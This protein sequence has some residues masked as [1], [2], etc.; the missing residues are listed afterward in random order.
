MSGMKRPGLNRNGRIFFGMQR[1]PTVLFFTACMVA[2]FFFAHAENVLPTPTERAS[3]SDSLS[4]VENSVV[5]I[6]ANVRLPDPFRPWT[7]QEPKEVTGS[8]VIIDGK[9]ILTN[10]HVVLYA[11]EVQVQANQSG[12]KVSATVEAVAPGIDLAVLKVEDETLFETRPPLKRASTLPDIKDVVMVYGFPTGG[13]SLSITKGIVSRIEFTNYNYPV[14]GLRIQIDAAINPGNSGGPVVV[15]NKI[16]GLAFSHLQGAQNIGYIIPCE[17]IELFLE[18]ISNGRYDGKPALFD[19]FQTLENGALRSFL[20]LDKAVE[21]LVV[22]QPFSNDPSY[23]LKE[24]DVITKIGDTQIDNQGMI[25]LNGNLRISFRYLVQKIA[26]NGSVPLTI[27]RAGKTLKLNVPVSS[28]RP[29]LIAGLQGAYP[30]YFIFGPLV[31]SKATT[32]FVGGFNSGSSSLLP[33]LSFTGSPLAT[34]LGDAPS[35]DAEELVV[36]SS[37]FFP[38]R[39][40]KGYSNP[41]G[42]VV[43]TVND[44]PI[45]SFRHLVEVLRDNRMDV[46]RFDFSRRGGE[47]LVFLRRDMIAATDEILTDNGIRSQGSPDAMAVWNGKLAR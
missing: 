40:A 7:K 24:W 42:A 27:V 39:L 23:P 15:G 34:R 41:A 19:E 20:K 8:G 13:A 26:K 22:H 33:L 4:Q 31:F 5:K 14:S 36:V 10:A 3:E 1:L 32:E 30:P 17:E 37:P 29:L 12:D 38:H 18:G 45:K 16:I 21:G 28:T 47:K 11:S 35:S 2:P 6:F 44:I 25:R 43:R 46:I 9:R